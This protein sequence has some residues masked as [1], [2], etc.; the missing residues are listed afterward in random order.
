MINTRAPDGANKYRSK[1]HST[2]Q[3]PTKQ[4]HK[5]KENKYR[6]KLLSTEQPPPKQT[7]KT[8]KYRS[9][10]LSTEQTHKTKKKKYRSRLLFSIVGNEIS[11][12]KV[13]SL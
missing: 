2:E 6:S 4:T 13:T 12:S 5:T 1:L 7:H 8:K 10:L 3:Q 11:V 9:R